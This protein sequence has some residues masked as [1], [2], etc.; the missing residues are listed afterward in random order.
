MVYVLTPDFVRYLSRRWKI[1]QKTV[2]SAAQREF[3]LL[4]RQNWKQCDRKKSEYDGFVLIE[5]LM[6]YG[7]N[8]LLRTGIIAKA[9][10][11]E[12]LLTPLVVFDSYIE[13]EDGKIALYKSFDIEVFESTQNYQTSYFQK[14]HNA[15]QAL[16]FYRTVNKPED[17]LILEYKGIVFGDLL[18][19][20]ILKN[21]PGMVTLATI[22]TN[23]LFYIYETLQLLC[24]YSRFLDKNAI[25]LF[26]STHSQYLTFGLLLRV[27]LSKNIPV[28]ETTDIQLFFHQKKQARWRHGSQPPSARRL[29]A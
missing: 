3:I 24:K 7:V 5:G 8:Y 28:F 23:E 12:L 16:K 11:E 10:E 27:C 19:D 26:I 18:Y 4:N 2:L 1:R 15:I 22:S 25:K 6:A 29:P 9:V 21:T 13:N 17:L 14:I 20:T